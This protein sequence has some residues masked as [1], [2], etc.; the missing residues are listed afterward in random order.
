MAW[1]DRATVG[2]LRVDAGGP[3]EPDHD[4]AGW[5]SRCYRRLV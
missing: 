4:E 5:E 3:V 1:L 2:N